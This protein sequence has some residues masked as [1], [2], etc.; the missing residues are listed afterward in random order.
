MGRLGIALQCYSNGDNFFGDKVNDEK[1]HRIFVFIGGF[2]LERK[3]REVGKLGSWEA[4]NGKFK[5]FDTR[6]FGR[7]QRNSWN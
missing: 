1:F 6:K 4:G 7:E 2:L 5:G 3:G